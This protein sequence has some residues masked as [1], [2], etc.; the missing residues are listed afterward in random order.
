MAFSFNELSPALFEAVSSLGYEDPTEIQSRAI[1]VLLHGDSDFVGQ[2]QTGTG[3]TAAF[4]LPLLEKI[5]YG[6]KGVQALILSPTRELANQI[7]EE[8]KKF[9]Q[10]TKLKTAIVYGGVGYR[11]QIDEMRKAH[12]VIAT[13]GRAIDHIEK[14]Y[15]K[16]SK[17]NYVVIDEA[18][19]M[20]NM[21]FIEDVEKIID[22]TPENVIRWM[23]SATMPPAIL[24]LVN[25]KL[26]SPQMVQVKKKTLS[27][28]NVVQNFFELNR[29]DFLKALKVI[30]LSEEDFYGI[31]FCETREETRQFAEKLATLGKRVAALHGDLN[32]QQ[33][34]QAMKAFKDRRLD[35]LVCTDVAA[36][37]LDVSQVTHVINMGLP[38]N[39]DSYVHRIGRTGRA[40]QKGVAISLISPN[41]FRNLKSIERLTNQR[42]VRYELPKASMIKKNKITVELERMNATKDAIVERGQEFS[43]DESYE[44]FSEYFESLSKEEMAKLLFSYHYKK[45]LRVIDESID[46]LKQTLIGL[47]SNKQAKPGRRARFKGREES[48]NGNSGGGSRRRNRN[49][50][51]SQSSDSS[52]N[53]SRDK[54]KSSSRRRPRRP[55]A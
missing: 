22:E 36:R 3:K 10:N 20:L 16:L 33:R 11:Q 23:F 15:L 8:L 13:P 42:M 38:R 54:S 32:Q 44:E 47:R 18:D 12:I 43:V 37:G 21:G 41:E 14:G 39:H 53:S 40:G 24:K 48:R 26:N 25:E 19:E 52:R 34:D 55:R 5:D 49:Q 4:C 17:C 30:I 1:P 50:R 35:I 28:E 6:R 31:V 46:V 2:A 29:R 7:N 27:N 51:G 45:D 9:S